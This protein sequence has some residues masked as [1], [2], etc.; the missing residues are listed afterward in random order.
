MGLTPTSLSRVQRRRG[1]LVGRLAP[2]PVPGAPISAPATIPPTIISEAQIKA[3]S[4]NAKAIIDA[5]N[6]L[7]SATR[8]AKSL[9]PD[10]LAVLSDPARAR[11]GA[12]R[13][14][15]MVDF[16]DLHVEC[17][18]TSM[19]EDFATAPKA[20]QPPFLSSG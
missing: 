19:H 5:T 10:Q 13:A 8:K 3:M 6:A 16:S 9:S 11:Q 2:V 20:G 14:T 12:V 7:T 17:F 18:V 1:R 4:D 15:G